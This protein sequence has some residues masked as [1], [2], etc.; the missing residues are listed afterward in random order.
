MKGLLVVISAPSGAGKST[1]ISRLTA[2]E[3]GFAFSVSHTTR[4]PRPGEVDGVHYHFVDD[5]R[6]AAIERTD[7]FVEWA[8]VHG[9]RYGTSVAEVQRLLSK[10]RDVIFDLDYQGGRALMRRFPEAVTIF[11]L[12]PSMAEIRRRLDGRATDDESTIRLRLQNARVEIA[13][14]GEYGYTVTNDDLD[15]AVEDVLAIL[16]AERLRAIRHAARIREL[17]AEE[18]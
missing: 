11:V 13:A 17:V 18:V 5:D 10:G 9:C 7:G 1:I 14:A 6:F 15:R 16:R 2:A 12:P 3:P 4:P 8:Y